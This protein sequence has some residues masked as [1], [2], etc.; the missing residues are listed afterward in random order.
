MRTIIRLKERKEKWVKILGKGEMRLGLRMQ[1]NGK[2]ESY[3]FD[4][5]T[6]QV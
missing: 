4:G 6:V 2:K 5:G 3:G 1:D